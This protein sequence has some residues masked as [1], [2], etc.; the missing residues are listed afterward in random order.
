MKKFLS[1]AIACAAISFGAA[2]PAS[3]AD[4][5]GYFTFAGAYKSFA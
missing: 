2:A 3:T 1:V 5:C 4:S